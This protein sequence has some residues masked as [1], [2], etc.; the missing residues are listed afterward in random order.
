MKLLK[1]I[2][3]STLVVSIVSCSEKP[4]T[5]N[6]K[7]TNQKAAITK[8]VTSKVPDTT[9]AEFI[10]VAAAAPAVVKQESASNN[11]DP[12]NITSEADFN[13]QIIKSGKL[14]LVDFY[15]DWCGPCRMLTP[16]INKLAAEY[17]GK[18]IV[19]KVNVDKL[20]ELATEY[21]VGGIPCVILF[22]DGKQVDQIV[23]LRRIDA[24]KDAI[25]KVL[26][27]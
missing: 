16:T 2:I 8:D 23:G 24:Y 6:Q 1:F 14:A 5:A 13:A 15:A 10:K 25:S 21:K 7:T 9:N 4:E 27:K 12:V 11:S 22:K 19:A 26:G 17:A 3:L 20:K 18:V